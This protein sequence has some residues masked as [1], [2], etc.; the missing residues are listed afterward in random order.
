MCHQ[1][2]FLEA[3]VLGS[4]L[5]VSVFHAHHRAWPREGTHH[6][7][8][9]WIVLKQQEEVW[10]VWAQTRGPRVSDETTEYRN[11]ALLIPQAAKQPGSTLRAEHSH[12]TLEKKRIQILLHTLVTS[13][14]QALLCRYY[15]TQILCSTLLMKSHAWYARV[16]L[17]TP[18]LPP[19][20]CPNTGR[21]LQRP[22]L[23]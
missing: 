5:F 3:R 14:Y 7:I 2:L 6:Q 8:H 13:S 16:F 19:R 23:Q 22:Y 10:P 20:G 17:C 12:A 15:F 1:S 9:A 21:L 11:R 4:N 18:T